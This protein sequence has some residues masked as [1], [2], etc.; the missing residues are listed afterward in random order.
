[1]PESILDYL[2]RVHKE[3]VPRWLEECDFSSDFLLDRFFESRTVYYPGAGH[4]GSPIKLF[5]RSHSAHCFVWV[6]R[7][8]DFDDLR[9]G[10][11]TGGFD[12][13]G[14][15]VCHVH[16]T[17]IVINANDGPPVAAL[18]CH[19]LVYDRRPYLGDEHGAERLA[20]L[21]IRAEAHIAYEQIYGGRFRENP[22]FA[23][24]LQECMRGPGD[25]PF[26]GP[27]PMYKAARKNGLPGFLLVGT[28]NTSPWPGYVRLEHFRRIRGGMPLSR[29]WLYQLR[30]GKRREHAEQ[31]RPHLRVA[32]R[33]HLPEDRLVEWLEFNGV[34]PPSGSRWSL[35][36][37]RR[38]GRRLGLWPY[39]P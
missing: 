16:Q 13:K 24:V 3:P 6:D 29:R 27:S 10:A 15:D 1:M 34:P 36:T 38:I 25:P 17:D 28:D 33:F 26:G 8:Y 14:Y 5:N 31:V 39:R 9:S 23:V 32:A 30:A 37:V 20:L 21:V 18:P 22:P 7:C 11:G 12:L 2:H 4:D 19:M 35:R